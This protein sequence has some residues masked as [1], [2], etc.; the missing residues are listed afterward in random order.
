M[1]DILF[2]HP[3]KT[4]GILSWPLASACTLAPSRASAY[5][6]LV[7]AEMAP[8]PMFARGACASRSILKLSKLTFSWTSP[9]ERPF[10]SELQVSRATQPK[11]SYSSIRNASTWLSKFCE[12]WAIRTLLYCVCVCVCVKI[13]FLSLS[14]TRS[15][16][17]HVH[18]C[19]QV[20][21]Y[22]NA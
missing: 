2:A 15:F 18:V 19:M 4:P 3:K 5:T 20:C 1:C 14:L 9:H 16:C 7:G 21:L 10:Q 22:I 11:H 8:P 6:L 17:M 12:Q 13:K